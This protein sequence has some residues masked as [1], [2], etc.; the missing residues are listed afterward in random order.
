MTQA[1]TSHMTEVLFCLQKLDDI[2]KLDLLADKTKDEIAEIWRQYY[3]DKNTVSAVIPADIYKQMHERF[4]KYKTVWIAHFFNQICF[5]F[6]NDFFT[7]TLATFFHW[8]FFV[9]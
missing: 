2:I 4:Q 7:P 1:E 8:F 5:L 3:A 6:Q 9:F